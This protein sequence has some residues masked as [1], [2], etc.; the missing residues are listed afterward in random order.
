MRHPWLLA[1]VHWMLIAA[2]FASTVLVP[3]Q[4]AR[5][6]FHAHAE[7]PMATA[8]MPCHDPAPPAQD[9]PCEGCTQATCDMAAC[10]GSACL[11]PMN[12]SGPLVARSA[13]IAAWHSSAI[14]IDRVDRPLR[15]PIA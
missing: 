5:A 8:D 9:D 14:A 10:L 13:V 6:A 15:P 11:P 4:M 3:A 2:L 1:A 12:R 7:V